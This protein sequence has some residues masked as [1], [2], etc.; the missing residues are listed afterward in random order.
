MAILHVYF[1]NWQS[2]LRV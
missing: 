2:E 1:V